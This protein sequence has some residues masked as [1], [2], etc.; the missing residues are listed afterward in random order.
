MTGFRVLVAKELREFVRGWRG[1]VLIGLI[2]LF[3]LTGPILA[4]Y[5]REIL[6][7]SLGDQAGMFPIP[8]PTYVD[9]YLQW[10]K[11]LGD[12]VLF[13]V[14]ILFGG[15]IAAECRS[16]TAALVV[17]KPP[18]RTAFVLAK[19]LA[20]LVCLAVVVAVGTAVTWAVTALLFPGAPAVPLLAA[21]GAWLVYAA[22]LLAVVVAASA[23]VGSTGAAAGLGFGVIVLLTVGGLADVLVRYTPVGLRSVP[24]ALAS[25]APA[26]WGWPV[27]ST[28]VAT[29]LVVWLAVAVFR[30]REI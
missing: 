22:F 13:A 20:H 26:A 17:V 23:A 9:A 25:G 10:T 19:F 3:A 11:N 16:G 14:V 30:R 24:S 1:W 2:G 4:R 6:Q 5:T 12:L 21:T 15:T 29:V 18:S 8:D 28:A 27:S 7:A